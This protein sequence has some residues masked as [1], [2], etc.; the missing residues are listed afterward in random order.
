[1]STCPIN[2]LISY[3]YLGKDKALCKKAFDMVEQRK[4]KLMIDSGAFSCFNN[5]SSFAH[6]TLE[7]YISFLNEYGHLSEKYVM[8]D[9]IGE[10]E[11]SVANYE[12]MIGAG[13]RPMYVVIMADNDFDYINRTLSVNQNICVAGGATNKNDWM[14]H[15]FQQVKEMTNNKA[16]I[17]GLGY[18]TFPKMLQLGLTSV[19]SSSWKTAPSGFGQTIY[20]DEKGR[21]TYRISKDKFFDDLTEERK[22]FLR[23][24]KITPA[25]IMNKENQSSD[26]SVFSF[27][28]RLKILQLQ[29]YCKRHGLDYF[30]AL[31]SKSDLDCLQ[32]LNENNDITYQ[33]YKEYVK[34]YSQ[35]ND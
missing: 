19:D 28:S 21:K 18:F 3:A 12:R 6:V 7:N 25:D 32:M 17:H 5:P 11:K 2:I 26:G 24:H 15:R 10:K 16:L 13:L 34:G 8:L 22:T 29:R 9:V 31:S 27:L 35:S 1:M 20:F 23:K 33:Q 4:I 30:L 14:V